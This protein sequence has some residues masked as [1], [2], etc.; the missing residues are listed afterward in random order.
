MEF[1]SKAPNHISVRDFQ[2]YGDDAAFFISESRLMMAVSRLGSF[3]SKLFLMPQW[4][5]LTLSLYSS[6]TPHIRPGGLI[7]SD[8]I[9]LFDTH[10][11]RLPSY[12]SDPAVLPLPLDVVPRMEQLIALVT[13]ALSLDH[14]LLRVMCDQRQRLI[15][16]QCDALLRRPVLAGG[17]PGAAAAAGGAASPNANKRRKQNQGVAFGAAAVLPAVPPA[18]PLNWSSSPIRLSEFPSGSSPCFHYLCDKPPCAGEKV[19]KQSPR[20]RSHAPFPQNLAS[21]KAAFKAWLLA[22]YHF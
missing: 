14:E 3:Y 21:R 2:P 19:C 13:A 10:L 16:A 9:E 17:S 1:D 20:Q 5:H 15:N 4:S 7:M 18:A 11:H 12:L 8:V 22:N 6:L